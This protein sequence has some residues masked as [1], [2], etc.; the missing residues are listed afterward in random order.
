[1]VYVDDFKMAGPSVN[2]AK[3][4]SLIRQK[5]KYDEP[6]ALTKCLGCEHLVRDTNVGGVS[7]K[8]MEYNTRPFFEQCMESYLPLLKNIID[9]LK[10]A[11]TP[12][13]DESKAESI[14]NYSK[15]GLLAPIAFMKVMHGA[16][17]ARFDLLRPIAALASKITKWDTLCEIMLHRPVCYLNSS[18]TTDSRGTLVI[19]VKILT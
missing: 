8:Q 1:M 7:V 17:L 4:W 2:F 15:E 16:R 18:L 11:K 3:G 9:T 12:F 14:T 13:L 5:F 19:V 10:F 6:H